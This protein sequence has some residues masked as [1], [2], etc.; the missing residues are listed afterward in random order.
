MKRLMLV[1]SVAALALIAAASA[2]SKDVTVGHSGWNWGNPQPQGN[3]LRAIEFQGAR[4]FAAGEFGTLLR[5]EDRGRSWTGIPTGTT[6]A[7]THISIAGDTSVVVG[8]GCVL[9]RS[10]DGGTSVAALPVTCKP[11]IA[12]LSFPSAQ[13]G[14]LLLADGL[15]SKTTDGGATFNPGG[16]IPGTEAAGATG[17]ADDPT[18]IFFTDDNTGFAVTRGA[19]GGAVYRTSDR[20]VT[21]FQRTTSPQGLNGVFFPDP[22]IG[23]AVGAANTVLKTTDGGETWAPKTVPDS[24]PVSDLMSIRCATTSNCMIATED[25]QR[26][27]RTTNGGNGANSFS[28]FNPAAQKIFAVAFSTPSQALAVGERGATVL[29]TNADAGT[30][31]FVPVADQPLS[32][33][34]SRLRAAAGSL[35]L[36]PGESG[37]LARSTDGGRHWTTLQVP[38]SAD[39]RDAWFAD[40]TVGFA[41]DV[42]GQVQRTLDGGDGW[43][44]VAT[45]TSARPNALYAPD[46]SVVLLIGPKGIRR[47]TS[48]VDPQFDLVESKAA[49]AA[50]LTDY[51]RTAGSA[52]FAYG[53]KAL[54]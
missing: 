46:G 39:L 3:T 42:S 19:A 31:S 33:S 28:A 30:P 7:I 16:P 50:T 36:A 25:G 5:A 6:A 21:W 20:G 15:I 26:V 53:R 35:V 38:T 43:G 10:D 41:L 32:G 11:G 48:A 14:Y 51:D 22:A 17:A 47:A 45:G 2:Q 24:V 44:E 52:L 18:D 9:R 54:I 34:F 49:N 13:T 29:S 23:Y 1:L 27:L 12:S 40:G 8:G 4:G 37:K